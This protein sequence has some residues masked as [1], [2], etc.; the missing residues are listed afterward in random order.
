[1]VRQTALEYL[2][3]A[4]ESYLNLPRQY[5]TLHRVEDGKTPSQVLVD[6][7]DLLEVKLSEISDDI[8]GNDAD[9]LLANGRFLREKFGRSELD[10][11]PP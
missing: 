5:A 10:P 9:R 8:A 4:L 7:L 1:I 3:A 2:P 6:Q 11:P